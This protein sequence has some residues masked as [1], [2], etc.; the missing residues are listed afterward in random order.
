MDYKLGYKFYSILSGYFYIKVNNCKYKVIYPSVEIKYKAEELYVDIM[1]DAKFETSYMTD[2]QVNNILQTYKFWS[3]DMQ[4]RLDFCKDQ[5]E[6]LKIDLYTDY[7]NKEKRKEN[8]EG[9]EQLKKNVATLNTAKHSL[10]YLK[11]E[12]YATSVKNQ[13]IISQRILDS[14]NKNIF[15]DNYED[16]DLAA[17]AKFLKPIEENMVTATDLRNIAKSELWGSYN[18]QDNVFGPSI[19]LNDDQRNLLTLNKM[20]NNVKQHQDCPSDD[21]INDDD[22]LDGWFLFQNRKVKKKNLQNKLKSRVNGKVAKHDNIFIFANTPEETKAIHDL[23]N[24]EGKRTLQM[25]HNTV[26]KE[27]QVK[28]EEIPI[29]RQQLID[30]KTKDSLK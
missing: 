12:H 7:S 15:N 9:L 17:L 3:P 22:A 27:G 4:E 26:E 29:V 5:I 10:D 6:E 19:E 13:Y 18:V 30:E 8:K 21:I 24:L 28:W 20:Y 14:N 2:Q 23:N 1:E 16:M 25:I 11:L